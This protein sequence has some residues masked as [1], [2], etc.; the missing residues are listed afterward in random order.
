MSTHAY[1]NGVVSIDSSAT[2][3][4]SDAKSVILQLTTCLG[5]EILN[6]TTSAKIDALEPLHA[7]VVMRLKDMR[8]TVDWTSTERSCIENTLHNYKQIIIADPLKVSV[9]TT[10]TG[11][12]SFG[13]FPSGASGRAA[14][15]AESDDDDEIRIRRSPQR[16]PTD[17]R[18]FEDSS[19]SSIDPESVHTDPK[20]RNVS[21]T[22]MHEMFMKFE[23][24]ENR[25]RIE[26]ENM[27][28][29]MT[30]LQDAL[31]NM[32]NQMTDSLKEINDSVDRVHE[33][34]STTVNRVPGSSESPV[35]DTTSALQH[36]MEILERF[37][38][39]NSE[40]SVRN[41]LTCI[42]ESWSRLIDMYN[43]GK[44]TVENLQRSVA[45]P[46]NA[47]ASS[48]S[49]ASPG[50]GRAAAASSTSVASPGHG[51]ASGSTKFSDA[52]LEYYREHKRSTRSHHTPGRGEAT[53]HG[54]PSKGRESLGLEQ[55]ATSRRHMES[56]H[57]GE[58]RHTPEHG[59]ATHK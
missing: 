15:A 26:F 8:G 40:N 31:Q 20:T 42:V 5:E 33:S 50:P 21:M 22:H 27:E 44:P 48:S 34:I 10:N 41:E 45:P 39:A 55:I 3:Q 25:R 13:V 6:A 43:M 56:K 36:K 30:D 16:K 52:A 12:T 9:P 47:A 49:V 1:N 59:E 4:T 46:R 29:K 19:E 14:G 38:D 17:N 2:S 28:N 11:M 37:V 54:E 51:R 53:I 57:S 7:E 18:L 24:N 32:E 23:T 35:E 58:S